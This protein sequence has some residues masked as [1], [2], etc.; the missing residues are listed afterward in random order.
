MSGDMKK[1]LNLTLV[2]ASFTLFISCA[3]GPKVPKIIDASGRG[4]IKAINKLLSKG[5]NVNA[6][7]NEGVTALALASQEGH[8][9]IVQLLKNAGAK[10]K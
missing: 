8:E 4:D 5:A 3:S 7:T 9:K 10:E 2:L 6:K 1:A